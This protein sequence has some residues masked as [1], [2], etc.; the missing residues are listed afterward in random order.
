MIIIQ[1]CLIRSY[2]FLEKII[3]EDN[4]LDPFCYC[5]VAKSC[6]IL[7]DPMDCSLPHF[8]VHGTFQARILKWVAI[9]FSM[10]LSINCWMF[11]IAFRKTIKWRHLVVTTQSVW[12]SL[13]ISNVTSSLMLY[14]EIAN[15][16]MFPENHKQNINNSSWSKLSNTQNNLPPKKKAG[17]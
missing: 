12:S 6:P 7:C 8:S 1:N 2:A 13:A 11:Y 16:Y 3:W 4:V 17:T 5:W 9:S 15:W 10:L 14:T